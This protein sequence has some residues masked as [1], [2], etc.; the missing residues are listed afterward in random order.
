MRRGA[1]PRTLLLLPL[2]AA[3]VRAELEP[4]GSLEISIRTRFVVALA[5]PVSGV[6]SVAAQVAPVPTGVPAVDAAGLVVPVMES[7]SMRMRPWP[8]LPPGPFQ[9]GSSAPDPPVPPTARASPLPRVAVFAAIYTLPA[10]PP[11]PSPLSP[12]DGA[13]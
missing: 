6:S 10:D 11:P 1:I 8:P 2:L 13:S 5:S 9:V 3:M 7:A 4:L 12:E